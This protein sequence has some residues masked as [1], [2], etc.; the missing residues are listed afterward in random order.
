MS[1][2]LRREGRRREREGVK[3]KK[4]NISSNGGRIIGL[5]VAIPEI[6]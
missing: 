5:T 4:K 1:E 6:P 2:D 3:K